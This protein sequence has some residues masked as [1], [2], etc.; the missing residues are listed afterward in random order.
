VDQREVDGGGDGVRGW[1]NG[2]G[3]GVGMCGEGRG[4]GGDGGGVGLSVW[5]L[6]ECVV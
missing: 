3:G 5:L 1:W 4:V 2:T 6:G